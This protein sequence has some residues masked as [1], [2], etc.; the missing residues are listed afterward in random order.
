MTEAKPRLTL[1]F[2]FVMTMIG[3]GVAIL[4]M[5]ID[6]Q[7]KRDIVAHATAVRQ[8]IDELLAHRGEN[9]NA[10]STPDTAHSDD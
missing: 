10:G 2:M 6:Q 3:L 7:I 1:E 5:V 9:V 8:S 4:V